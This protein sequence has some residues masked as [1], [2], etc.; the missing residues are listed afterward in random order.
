MICNRLGGMVEVISI[1]F[2]SVLGA[3]FIFSSSR[4]GEGE[5]GFESFRFF[6]IWSFG[7]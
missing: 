4:K 6:T 2:G 1:I 5:K 3:K 7:S